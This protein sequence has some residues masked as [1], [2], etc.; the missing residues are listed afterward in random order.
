LALGVQFE[1]LDR[2]KAVHYGIWWKAIRDQFPKVEEHNALP[3]IVEPLDMAQ[4]VEVKL[5]ISDRPPPVRLWFLN[6][7]ATRL[8]QVQ[9][10]RFVYNWRKRGPSK[11]PYPSYDVLIE[12]FMKHLESFCDFVAEGKHGAF[13]PTMCEITYVDH[14]VAGQG[15]KD[16]S[17]MHKLIAP[18]SPQYS[19]DFLPPMES[20]LF[21]TSYLFKK[22][23]K[24]LG[25]LRV[26]AN[27]AFRGKEKEPITVMNV[28][29]F[30]PPIGPNIEGIRK[31][32]DRAHE[33]TVR[34]FTSMTPK[35]M[36]KV[37]GRTQ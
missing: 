18:V 28:G 3:P 5:R 35:E 7:E 26:N 19:D 21:N 2:L 16:H 4:T 15:W 1:C 20:L 13:V 24:A 23:A 32:L 33:W 29:A 27:P 8:I 11:E 31:A 6:E 25:R 34:G 9:N 12:D 10:D 30:A 22:G 37:W 17:E 36:H 14:I